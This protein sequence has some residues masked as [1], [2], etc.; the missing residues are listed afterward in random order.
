MKKKILLIMTTVVAFALF[1][2][3]AMAVTVKTEEDFYTT[4]ESKKTVEIKSDFNIKLEKDINITKV[5]TIGASYGK[6]VS[7]TTD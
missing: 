7:M 5:V 1:I 6:D 3:N 2:P 4:I